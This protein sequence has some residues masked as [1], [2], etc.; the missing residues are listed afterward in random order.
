MNIRVHVSYVFS[1]NT[2]SSGVAGSYSSSLFSFLRDFHTCPPYWLYQFTLPPTV[3][4]ASLFSTPSPASLVAHLVK[5]RP[6]VRE[7]WLDPWVGKIPWW[8]LPTSIFW[9]GEFH[10]LYRPGGHK[11]SDTTEQLSLHFTSDF[12]MMAILTGVRW[13]FMWF[14]FMFL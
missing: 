6:A 4:E 13:Y 7:T 2:H 11:E 14:W 3:Q 1:R 5:N 10:G 12:L 9:P 8:R